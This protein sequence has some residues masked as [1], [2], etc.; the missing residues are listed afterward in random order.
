MHQNPTPFPQSKLLGRRPFLTASVLGAGALSLSACGSN[1]QQNTA[2]ESASASASAKPSTSSAPAQFAGT[3]QV[4]PAADEIEINPVDPVKVTATDATLTSVQVKTLDAQGMEVPA[5]GAFN[6]EKTVWTSSAPLNFDSQYTVTW[7]AKDAQGTAGSGE[8]VF[9]TVSAANE[10]DLSMNVKE[11]AQ[12]GVGQIIEIRFSEP[13]TNKAEVEKAIKVT[14]GGDQ[15][16]KF[17]WYSDNM[18]RYRPEKYWAANSAVK[19]QANVLGVDFGNGMIGNANVVRNFKTGD[20]HYA[21][22]D[23]KTKTIKL[24]VNDKLVREN[25]I[26]LGDPEWPSVVGQLVI[27]EQSQKYFFNP[28]SLGLKKGDPHWYEPFYATNVS[29]LTESGVFVHQALPSAYPYVG[30]ADISHGCIGMLP[31]DIQYFFDLFKVGDIVETQNTGYQQ[32]NP[33]NGFGDWN[34]PFAHYQD[35]SWKGNW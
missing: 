15:K 17:R 35:T 23:D 2:T 7:A 25:P 30:V 31:E 9:S 13:V 22:A 11:G 12:Y 20:K 34:I 26:T 3:V 19:V 8:S 10:A 33:D 1:T 6:K 29:R 18:V 16:G 28:E 14:G 32:A 4:T 27:M 21:Y 24:Y 5:E